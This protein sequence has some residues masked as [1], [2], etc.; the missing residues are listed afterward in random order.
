MSEGY[1]YRVRRETSTRFWVNNPTIEDAERAIAAGAI[2]CTVNPT[3]CSH[4][5]KSKSESAY[6]L[7]VID[8]IVQQAADDDTAADLV[9]QRL[10]KRLMEK[11]LPLYDRQP[12]LEGFVSIQGDPHADDDPDH[13]V[14]EALRYRKL[15]RNSIMKIPC[16]DA[17]LRA[18]EILIAEDTP[19][20]A[21]EVFAIAQ[22]AETC[23]LYRRVSEESGKRPPFYVTH[24]SG[25]FDEFLAGV[26][27]SEGIDISPEAL[28]SAGCAVARKQYRIMQERRYPGIMLGG[29]A[30]GTYHFT[31]M[32]GGAVH[33]TINWSTAEELLAAD[34]PVLFRIGAETPRSVI[35]QLCDKLPDFRK[36]F[37]DEGL[38]REEFKVYGPLQYFRDMFVKGWDV[39]LQTIRERRQRSLASASLR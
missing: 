10:V 20:I 3:F 39:L 2:S 13:I 29:G 21:T 23:E 18:I 14:E 17:G 33:V 36:A 15:A 38:A 9:Q 7:S 4:M 34:P 32:V 28:S 25:I 37:L 5:I 31:E 12:G 6:A 11:F 22:V 35:D 8:S 19:V 24:I 26:V 1:F 27:K 16:T 30:R